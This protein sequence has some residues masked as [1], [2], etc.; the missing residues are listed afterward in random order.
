MSLKAALRKLDTQRLQTLDQRGC[1]QPTA[2][3]KT[4]LLAFTSDNW[5][6]EGAVA[7][8]REQ[9]LEWPTFKLS[10]APAGRLQLQELQVRQQQV[11]TSPPTAVMTAFFDRPRTM[12]A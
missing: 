6:P 7:T 2:T 3:G 4:N 11:C 1:R 5:E 8:A 10:S 12:L 9:V